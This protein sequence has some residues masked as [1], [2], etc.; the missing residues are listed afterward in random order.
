VGALGK[1]E[2][3]AV[4]GQEGELRRFFNMFLPEARVTEENWEL[5]I[6]NVGAGRPWQEF[7]VL[8]SQFLI[9]GAGRQLG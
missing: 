5:G 8:N 1:F 2:E 9:V 6:R 7:L 3:L 4:L